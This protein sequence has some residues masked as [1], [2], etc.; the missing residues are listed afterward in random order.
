MPAPAHAPIYETNDII[1][2]YGEVPANKDRIGLFWFLP[3]GEITRDKDVAEHI[4]KR[5]DRMIQVN[6]K[7]YDRS[8][9]W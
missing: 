3:G 9:I 7:R 8:L 6:M 5:L 4:A 1:H 2:G